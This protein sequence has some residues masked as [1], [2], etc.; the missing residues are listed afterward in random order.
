MSSMREPMIKLGVISV[1]ALQYGNPQLEQQFKMIEG[2]ATDQ[3]VEDTKHLFPPEN[4]SGQVKQELNLLRQKMDSLANSQVRNEYLSID[5]SLKGYVSMYASSKG[6]VGFEDWF[7]KMTLDTG[8]FILKLKYFFQRPRPYQLA[9]IFDLE[10]YPLMSCS[11]NSPKWS[12]ISSIFMR[13]I[14]AD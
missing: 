8:S 10:I 2:C 1:N 11:S 5:E 13:E 12:Y 14:L 3:Y 9:G 6:V 7:D 4:N